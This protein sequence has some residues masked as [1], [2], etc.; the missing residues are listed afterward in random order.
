MLVKGQAVETYSTSTSMGTFTPVSGA[1]SNLLATGTY[2]DDVSSAVTSIGFN[3]V[4]GGTTYTQFSV[5][6]NGNIRLGATAISGLTY[7][8]ISG[9]T[10]GFISPMGRD[11]EV[12]ASGFVRYEVTGTAPN[13]VLTIEWKDWS[14][15]ANASLMQFQAKLYETSN[16]INFVY[17]PITLAAGTSSTAQIGLRGGTLTTAF[18]NR[19]ST[20]TYFHT[21][22]WNIAGRGASSALT[23]PLNQANSVFPSSGLTYSFSPSATSTCNPTAV[24]TVG[25]ITTTSA[26]FTYTLPGT[27]TQ[28]QIR[29]RSECDFN[30]PSASSTWTTPTIMGTSPWT[31]SGLVPG[32]RYEWQFRASA[33][34]CTSAPG[35]WFNGGQFITTAGTCTVPS[36]VS[37]AY[38]STSASITYSAGGV[39]LEYYFG[40]GVVPAPSNC[41]GAPVASTTV[42]GTTITLVSLSPATAYTLYVRRACGLGDSSNWTAALAFTTS[43]LG[44]SVPYN[45]GFESAVVPAYPACVTGVS[46]PTR[47]TTATGAAPR[48]G[49]NFVNIRW[50]PATTNYLYSAPVTLT[51]STSYDFAAWYIT[52]GLAGWTSLR[53]YA[54]TAPTITGATLVATAATPGA[55]VYTQLKGA[56]IP[57]STG[58]YYLIVQS[59]HTTVPNDMSIDDISI[60]VSPPPPTITSFTPSSGCTG[61]TS[62]VIDGTNFTDATAV[63]FGGTNALSYIVNSATQI[64]AV[65][66]SGTSGTI[67]V[68]TSGGSVTSGSPITI[69]TTP[70]IPTYTGSGTAIIPV[71]TST[72]LSVTGGGGTFDWYT[73]ATGGTSIFT[74]ASYTTPNLCNNTTYY[75]EENSGSCVSPSRRAIT[76]NVTIPAITK[77]PANGLI[78]SVGGSVSMDATP[79]GA[80]SYTWT[81][82]SGLSPTTGATTTATPTVTTAYTLLADYG[83]GCVAS[84]P[85]NVGVI[86]GVTVAP[87]AS[88]AAICAGNTVTLNANLSS[89]GFGVASIPFVFST[90]PGTATTLCTNG[91]QNV[92]LQSGTLDD[93]GWSTLPIG[94]TYNYFGNNYTT[95]N[96]GTNGVLQFGAYNATDLGDYTYV[97][98]PNATEPANIIAAMASDMDL[99]TKGTIKYW[100]EGISPTRVFIVNWDSMGGYSGTNGYHTMQLKLYETTGIVEVHVALATKPSAKT[101]GLQDL[102]RTIGATP[103]GRNAFSTTITT[104]EAWR[105]S[106]PAAY[107]YAWTPG[108]YLDNTAIQIPTVSASAPAASYTYNV[109]VTNPT[110][111]CSADG[112]VSFSIVNTL[113][114]VATATPAATPICSSTNIAL[115]YTPVVTGATQ[116]WEV[117]TDGGGTWNPITGGT[118]ATYVTTQSVTSMYRV[119]VTC[120]ASST[121]AP[122][123]ALVQGAATDCYCIPAYTSGITAGDLI[124][125]IAITGTTLLNN[126]GIGTTGPSYT[127]YGPPIYT[128]PSFS[129]TLEAGIPYSVNITTGSFDGQNLAA[130]VDYNDNG[131]FDTT[132]RIGFSTAATTTAF[133]TTSF[134]INLACPAP[135]GVHRMRVRQVWLTAGSSIDPCASYGWGEAED[136]LVNVIPPSVCPPPN[137]ITA[138]SVTTTS[139]VIGWTAGC[140]ETSWDIFR[141]TSTALPTASTAPTFTNVTANPYTLTGLTAG[142][143][144]RV[145]VR[146]RCSS[147]NKSAWIPVLFNTLLINDGH[148]TPIDITPAIVVASPYAAAGFASVNTHLD[149]TIANNTTATFQSPGE[150]IGSCGASGITNKTLWYKLTTPFC[151]TPTLLISTNHPST[152]FDTRLSVYRRVDPNS[153]TGGYTEIGCNDDFVG[154]T[155]TITL[156]PNSALPTTNQYAPGESVYIQASGYGAASGNYG[157]VIDA[158]PTVPTI[159]SVG[160]GSAVADWSAV[161]APTWGSISGAYIQW[162]PVGAPATT[163][164]TWI[165]KDASSTTHTITGLMPGTAY[166]VWASYVCGNGGRWWSKKATFT[167]NATCTVA[168]APTITSIAPAPPRDCRRPSVTISAP[169]IEFSSYKIVRKRGSTLWYSGSYAPSASITYVDSRSLTYG[170]TYQYYIVGYCGTTIA[171]T[172]PMTN[173]TAC[174]SARMGDPSAEETDVVYTLPTGEMMYGLPFN[175]IAWQMSEGEG[176]INLQTTDAN[177]YFGREVA[178]DV[179]VAKVGAMSIYPNP[180]TSEA[181]ISY[182]LE[183]EVSS[184]VIRVMDAQGKEMMNETITNPEVSGIYN[185][186]LNNYSAGIYFVKI[187]AGDYTDA[188][189]L[190]VDRR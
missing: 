120:S 137:T 90:I 155:S 50:T 106:P 74:G 100:T 188:K 186:N 92:A 97:G 187:Q 103:P 45:E 111:G 189:K 166:E 144:Y 91:V 68:T 25:S 29:Y 57:P 52:D 147:T 67:A 180:A 140:T 54:N 162:R 161:L 7:S 46:A 143:T 33:G 151:A 117:S 53:I 113:S 64:T 85:A 130:W 88:V 26:N 178:K 27:V 87:T 21:Q 34:S 1:A 4:M 19:A 159:S 23:M 168:T 153:C 82:G 32:R 37:A 72:T 14:P 24:P 12:E 55:T 75:V 15:Y 118:T 175:E 11:G 102:S 2:H 73:T 16:N 126:S 127:F 116:Q 78:C 136:Y 177:T 17:G 121:S 39:G 81:G 49:T 135:Y 47:N 182:T 154:A 174:S 124:S 93:G 66:G 123:A 44:A 30:N 36:V 20:I 98:L 133:E 3:F 119:V 51:G 69:N 115:A 169:G 105:F 84:V 89:S 131:I 163:A 60:V 31:L 62:V 61:T 95:V 35:A 63:T 43:C 70:G 164:G 13:R 77:T 129:A 114:P 28:Y 156:T 96:L 184:M 80:T 59:I 138:T 86:P 141:T 152:D 109:A 134:T 142:T 145:Y 176:E 132:E 107:T 122:T 165:Y 148:C 101:I 8:P 170:W 128:G 58:D 112:D 167:T 5:N 190:V 56:Y 125:Q 181:T 40:T 108:T 65:V 150:P 139:A 146:A 172:S 22:H 48:T 41:T 9:L 6:S 94:F 179:V 79:L 71:N 110:T 171:Y 160:A 104:P 42:A 149:T 76:V 183:K 38:T 185:I 18:T 10:A 173:Y 99:R 83:G 157:L 158:E